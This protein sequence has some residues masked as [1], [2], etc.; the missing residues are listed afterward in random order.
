MIKE[1]MLA[2]HSSRPEGHKKGIKQ[3]VD[4][5]RCY[6]RG[7]ADKE[8]RGT[9]G[10]VSGFEESTGCRTVTPTRDH[11]QNISSQGR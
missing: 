3:M 1:E 2:I 7:S 5:F 6:V 11:D 9:W 8:T 10:G 4:H